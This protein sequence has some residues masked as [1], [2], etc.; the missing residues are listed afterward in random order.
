MLVLTIL[1][2]YEAVVPGGTFDI[3]PRQGQQKPQKRRFLVERVEPG[4]ATAEA[5]HA[6]SYFDYRSKVAVSDSS[7][8]PSAPR[9]CSLDFRIS[10]ER[11]GGLQKELEQLNKRLSTFN[12]NS[13]RVRLPVQMRRHGAIMLHGLEGTGKSLL[14]QRLAQA[15]WATVINIDESIIG[16]YMGQGQ[17]SLRKLFTRAIS[18]QPSLVIIDKADALVGKHDSEQQGMAVN[19]VPALATELEKVRDYE[20]MVVAAT[21]RPNDI[22]KTLRTPSRFRYEI[23]LPIPDVNARTQI[24][25]IHLDKGKDSPD[26]LCEIIGERTHG[27]VGSD[28]ESLCGAAL[29]RA[30]DRYM[31][32]KEPNEIPEE[33][34]KS[35]DTEE[36]TLKAEAGGVEV[37]LED[38][39]A[40]L[41]E[42]R[43]T[44]MREVFF[45]NPKVKWTDVGGSEEVKKA[46]YKVVER[47]FKVYRFLPV[48]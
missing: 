4:N 15:P 13:R 33:K 35:S 25:K 28:L 30:V 19:L 10:A 31:S 38:F 5:I 8:V 36:K 6:L 37:S 26:Q 42:I 1:A 23:E 29:E 14:L 32:V 12:G 2:R 22:D 45:E 7:S 18:N 40:A 46:L 20:V 48:L 11:I 9:Q 27:F 24:L 43:P 44:A 17:A 21:N 39:E 3:T 34:P 47:P 41:L 16:Q